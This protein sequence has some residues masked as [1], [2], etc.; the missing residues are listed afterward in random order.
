MQRH[1]FAMTVET[2]ADGDLLSVGEAVLDDLK[3]VMYGI[4]HTTKDGTE[5]EVETIGLLHG[6][7]FAEEE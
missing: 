3:H 4:V 6:A 1:T 7:Q 5:Y 2:E